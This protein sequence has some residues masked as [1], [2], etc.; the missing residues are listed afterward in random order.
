MPEESE[1]VALPVTVIGSDHSNLGSPTGGFFS[2]RL[3]HYSGEP[4]AKL[5]DCTQSEYL[6]SRGAKPTGLWFS[7]GDAWRLYVEDRKYFSQDALKFQTEVVLSSVARCSHIA[8]A[9]GIDA[10]TA[11]YSAISRAARAR[12]AG[13]DCVTSKKLCAANVNALDRESSADE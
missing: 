5:H 2:M 7:V 11:A 3:I 13:L 1:T 10:L 6:E 9:D 8:D 12:R 4:L